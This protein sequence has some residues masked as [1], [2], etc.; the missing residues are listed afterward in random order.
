MN[1]VQS[2]FTMNSVNFWVYKISLNS[3]I[4]F[5]SFL[6]TCFNWSVQFMKLKVFMVLY[7]VIFERLGIIIIII[8]I[9]SIS[10]TADYSNPSVIADARFQ[11]HLQ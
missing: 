5:Q 6:I 2:R 8:L 4:G 7:I 1:D 9:E 10:V 3:D 11:D